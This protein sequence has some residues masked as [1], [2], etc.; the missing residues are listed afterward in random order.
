MVTE[1]GANR[2]RTYHG[3]LQMTQ[4]TTFHTG[5]MVVDSS[6]LVAI[7]LEEPAATRIWEALAEPKVLRISAANLLETWMVLDRRGT[8]R[9][10]ELLTQLVSGLS[11]V[12]EPVTL[13]QVE[14]ARDAWRRYGRGSGHRA[15]LNFGDCF[16]YALATHL[17]EPLLFVGDDFSHTDVSAVLA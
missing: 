2:E 4:S 1:A 15:G 16:A 6:A 14:I 5:S 7:A 10:H 12:I 17:K 3:A 11:P 9:S 8:A 13:V